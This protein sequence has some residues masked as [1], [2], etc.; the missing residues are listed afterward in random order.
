MNC[1]NNKPIFILKKHT[2]NAMTDIS[3][4]DT[5]KEKKDVSVNSETSSESLSKKKPEDI[6][7]KPA[8]EKP[9]K[10][11]RTAKSKKT[12]DEESLPH[13]K[14]PKEFIRDL[15]K[16]SEIIT[17]NPMIA[18][19][20]RDVFECHLV[21]PFDRKTFPKI[22]NSMSMLLGAQ[23]TMV[24]MTSCHVNSAAFFED[25]IFATKDEDKNVRDSIWLI[26]HLTSIYGNRVQEAYSLSSGTMDED[27]HTIDVNTYRQEGDSPSWIINLN[28]SL[29]SGENLK[30]KMTPDSA[31]QLIEILSSELVNN[32]PK[33]YLDESLIKKCDK[34]CT[35]FYE[36]YIISKN[37]HDDENPA[38]YA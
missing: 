37:K 10:K 12:K 27:W 5:D 11:R 23:A 16:F 18:E 36:K 21:K 35:K 9:K 29:Y 26:Q 17:S 8:E 15:K 24:L 32:V 28:M 20:I 34:N 25:L 19:P 4:E 6:T 7:D 1:Q 38:G 13:S 14:V 3:N 30:I 33:E 22:V 31:F 2:F